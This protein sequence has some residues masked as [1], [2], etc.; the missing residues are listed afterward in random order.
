[1][2]K[3]ILLDTNCL[4]VLLIG[5]LDEGLLR[6]F[7]KTKDRKYVDSFPILQT[8]FYNTNIIFVANSYL[9]CELSHQTIEHKDFPDRS[10][11]DFIKTLQGLIENGKIEIRESPINQVLTHKSLYYLGMSDVSLLITNK[12]KNDIILLTFDQKLYNNSLS[13]QISSILFPL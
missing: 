6:R 10:K 4:I 3:Y 9:M 11:K 8:Y 1:M 13:Y 12:I 7:T 5:F 2:S